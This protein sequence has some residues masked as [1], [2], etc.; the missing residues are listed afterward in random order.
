MI[1]LRAIRNDVRWLRPA[2]VR[3]LAAIFI[4]GLLATL[5]AEASPSIR[6]LYPNGG[7]K[8]HTNETITIRWEAIGVDGEV[9]VEYSD[10]GQW[11]RVERTDAAA[12]SLSWT[13]R[14]TGELQRGAA[15]RTTD[16]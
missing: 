14:R 2:H 7:E 13:I 6:V 10:G 8:F 11:R 1:L 12:G 15:E 3:A 16:Y 9:E 5:H 4:L